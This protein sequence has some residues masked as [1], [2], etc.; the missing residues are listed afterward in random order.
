MKRNI[1]L[2]TCFF[3]SFAAFPQKP[4]S[5]SSSDI[6]L[7]LKKLN[8][9]GSVLYV[10]AHPDDENTWLLSYLAKSGLYRTGYLSMTRGDGGQNLIGDEQGVELGLIRTQEL[11]SARRIDGAEQYFTRAF[12]F[13]FSK[14]TSEALK[15]WD[16]EKILSDVVW[17]IR[18]F[19]PDVI[20][21]RFPEDDRAGHGHHSA[22]AVLAHEA[23]KAAADP[24]R[25]PEQFKY[26]VQPWQAKRLL[27][28]TFN[29][30]G[31]NTTNSED[32][33]KIN[34]G[35]YN[36]VIGKSIGEIASES[37]SQHKSQG[38][39]VPVLRGENWDYLKITEGDQPKSDL[40]EGVNTSWSR[41]EGAVGI[42][43]K[44]NELIDKF[45]N[46]DPSQSVNGLVDLYRAVSKLKDGNWKAKKLI[47]I[48][49]LIEACSGLFMEAFVND[50]YAVPGDSLRIGFNVISRNSGNSFLQRIS[51]DDFD[52]TLH[53]TLK[54]NRLIG[55]NKTILVGSSKPISQPYW[56]E[57]PMAKGSYVV[58]DQV[59]IGKPENDPA[60]LARFVIRIAGEDF[61]FEKPV[62]YKFR[63]PVKGEVIQ[64]VFVV[65]NVTV[66]TSPAILI[67]PANNKDSRMIGVSSTANANINATKATI[68]GMISEKEIFNATRDFALKKG[69]SKEFDF[70]VPSASLGG[71]EKSDLNARVTPAD[72][73]TQSANDLALGSINYDHIPDIRYFYKDK[74]RVLNI[75]L[76]TDGKSI[77][78][79]RGA[80]DK[81]PDALQQMG[82]N[83]TFL[84]QKDLTAAKLAKFDAVVMGIRAYNV[85]DWLD[86]AYDALMEYVNK[87][88]NLVVQ[89]NTN[90]FTGPLGKNR[91]GPYPLNISRGRVTDE[92]AAVN[93]KDASNLVLNWP[94]KITSR[95][96]EGWIQERAIYLP[97]KW[98]SAYHAVLGMKDEGENEQLSSILTAK[99]GKGRFIFTGLVFFRELP[100]GVP[101]AYRLFANLVANPNHK[102][103]NKKNGSK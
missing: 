88:G 79:V 65:P 27:W 83:V 14:K 21:T 29:F 30:G 82:Y 39:G 73:N 11:L 64:P 55:I 54:L 17:V 52:S 35:V 12:D 46:S 26:G 5:W 9:L 57:Q 28:N 23:F 4:A 95:D 60:F 8:V 97:D 101:G 86:N 51:V 47:E 62:R 69:N 7:G 44:V 32:Q 72:N 45:N 78:Y 16:K 96:F 33:F 10:A 53:D 99:Y 1:L 93:V 18:K 3:A 100:L 19:Q 76:I 80:G 34:V 41:V 98:D 37:R 103:N 102:I 63:D 24:T 68:S 87:G 56:L 42:E 74:V 59:S 50:E 61:Q 81:V 31:V 22:S 48:K 38:F 90:S 67:V 6:L 13:G 43:A 66:K 85:H 15:T 91:I 92:D 89:Y 70:A 75:D 77:G 20:I 49:D 36:S 94:N 71:A 2:L 25:F 84:D 40:L 58:N